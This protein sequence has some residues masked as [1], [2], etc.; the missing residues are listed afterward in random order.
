MCKK[1]ITAPRF[2][3]HG[4]VDVDHIFFLLYRFG[5]LLLSDFWIEIDRVVNDMI[6]IRHYLC[7]L[8]A[9][10]FSAILAGQQLDSIKVNLELKPD[11]W[12]ERLRSLTDGLNVI[13]FI[14]DTSMVLTENKN[15]R[16]QYFGDVL[17]DL[18]RETEN[19]FLIYR[20]YLVVIGD[21]TILQESRSS[22]F[23]QALQ[24]SLS[25]ANNKVDDLE[26]LVGDMEKVVS[27]GTTVINGKIVDGES[28]ESIIGATLLVREIGQGT[29]TDE[30]GKFQLQLVP[31]SYTLLV[32]YIGYQ[33]RQIPIRVF[34]S[35]DLD[36]VLNRS[37]IL[38]DE[39]VVE[40]KK[41]DENIQSVEV[42][43][44]RVSIREIEKLPSFLGEVDI[45]KGLLQQPGVSTIGE[46]SS[47]F[48]VRGGTVDQNLIIVDEGMIFNVSHALG[49]FSAFNSDILSDAVLYKGN[50]PAK[51]GGR[52]AS[53]LDVNIKDGNFQ[54]LRF[55]GGLGVVSSRLSLEGPLKKDKTSFLIS[56]RSTYSDWV[57]KA[58]KIP[59]VSTSSAFFYDVNA[60]FTHRFN[61]RNFI[62]V[63][64][65]SSADQFTYADEFGFD[66]ET[67]LGQINYRSVL[68]DHLFSTLSIIYSD[69]QSSLSDEAGHDASKLSIG[70]EYIKIKENLNFSFD[71]LTLDAG[72]S[73]INYQVN[74]GTV[75]PQGETSSVI[76][77]SVLEEEAREIAVY[78]DAIFKVTPRFSISGGLRFTI[79]QFL[80][81]RE[82]YEY[83]NPAKPML[84]EISGRN[85]LDE[86][87]IHEESL[88]QPR[89]SA[90]YLF[91]AQTSVKIGYARTS[92]Y[93]NQ[94]SNNDTPT[95]TSI[96]QLSNQYIPSQL[97]HNFSLG[98]F[99]NFKE[100]IWNTGLE[101]YY[102]H[103]DRL[104]DYRDFADLI[105]NDHLETE[106]LTGK[107][108]A[109]GVELS[110]KKQVGV[111]HGWLNYTWSR[112]LRKI[113]GINR[114]TWYPSNFDKPHDLSLVTNYQINKRN[115][116]S[117]YFTYST[118]RAITIPL[119]RHPVEGDIV[120]L[121]YSDRN[122]FRAPDYHR[123]DVSYTLGQGYRKSRK[124]K[125]SWTF[126]VYNL[127]AR[128]NAF[129]VYVVQDNLSKPKI[130]RLSVLGNAFPSLT[131]NFELL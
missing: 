22:E 74:P 98:Y 45:I 90:R 47:G 57:L 109:Y 18:V 46:G 60:K 123:L 77:A 19:S 106:L 94:I 69:Y 96:W 2:S 6:F 21:R 9:F 25:A 112:S 8:F 38:L 125:T 30:D 52:L 121:N 75:V 34:G 118:G 35:G 131:F 86:K 95:P 120:V 5:S 15:Y 122:A 23:Y 111:L 42:G 32:Q 101:L 85:F 13:L 80:G 102:R 65:Y 29:D 3:Q 83:L 39:V 107:G 40:A 91:D 62:S 24:Q 54:K 79:Y 72:I 4:P 76:P 51:Y 114:Q 7:L 36:I 103:I 82:M 93:I 66:Y 12:Q 70:T 119:D 73:L 92:Q 14:A 17:L 100:N 110:L 28:D 113:A 117:L 27:S 59:E 56:V 116:I 50:I 127:Y 126:S 48:N 129:S 11:N 78:S 41:R 89:F 87:I 53:V 124:F 130:N 67:L 104:I 64:G 1:E 33:E 37:S 49:F 61:E 58:V 105:A 99:K 88:L 81:P 31:G 43:V 115:V 108:Q 63:S 10:S 128:R 97:S 68:N 44:S 71:N 84:E 16:E 20:D 55:K 26:I